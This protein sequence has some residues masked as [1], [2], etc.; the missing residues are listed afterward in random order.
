MSNLPGLVG[1]HAGPKEQYHRLIKRDRA[2][3]QGTACG[4][5]PENVV[6][7]GSVEAR[8]RTPCLTCFPRGERR[9]PRSDS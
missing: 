5:A 9:P 8:D 2:M 7:A 4:R 3:V 1:K 6:L